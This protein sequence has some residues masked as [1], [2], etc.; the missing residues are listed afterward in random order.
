MFYSDHIQNYPVYVNRTLGE[1]QDSIKWETE[2]KILSGVVSFFSFL[3]GISLLSRV[4]TTYKD[5]IKKEHRPFKLEG[6]ILIANGV[7]SFLNV[8]QDVRKDIGLVVSALTPLAMFLYL[9][10]IDDPT[11]KE[12]TERRVKKKFETTKFKQEKK[13]KQKQE[14]E[15]RERARQISRETEERARLEHELALEQKKEEELQ[16]AIVPEVKEKKKRTSKKL[17]TEKMVQEIVHAVR[18]LN[19]KAKDLDP[20]SG[21]RS[22]RKI[23]SGKYK[24]G[25][26]RDRVSDEKIKEI[27]N[28]LKG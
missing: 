23:V 11:L 17:S 10:G 20:S 7:F 16:L 8:F 1:V 4:H 13:E 5:K 6:G 21:G 24:S 26:H 12:R 22:V 28:R 3:Y 18:N 2:K 25:D 9:S 19:Y 15:E 14:K 27:Y